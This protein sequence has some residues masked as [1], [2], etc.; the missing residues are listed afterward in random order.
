MKYRGNLVTAPDIQGT[1]TSKPPKNLK[2]LQGKGHTKDDARAG[3]EVVVRPHRGRGQDAA[4]PL[5]LDE[6]HVVPA[7]QGHAR[8]GRQA[9]GHEDDGRPG[10]GVP[11]LAEA[12]IARCR[13]HRSR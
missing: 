7:G 5:A 4:R 12:R 10:R 9:R 13:G 3:G 2:K 11:R 8:Q 1:G 6:G